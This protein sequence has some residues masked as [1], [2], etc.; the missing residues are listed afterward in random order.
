MTDDTMQQAREDTD[1]HGVSWALEELRLAEARLDRRRQGRAPTSRERA[2]TRWIFE[3]DDAGDPA[4]PSELAEHLGISQSTASELIAKL[5]DDGIVA[6]RQH[7]R[8]GRSKVLSPMNRNDHIEGDDALT[9]E[10]RIA[11]AH[12]TDEQAI[13]VRDFLD[14]LRELVD[15]AEPR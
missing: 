13:A 6:T 8:D 7:P 4:T 1:E 14:H 2:A 12:L 15:R 3:R 9:D 5:V 11:V 10:I